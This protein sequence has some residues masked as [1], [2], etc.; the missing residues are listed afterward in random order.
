MML[1]WKCDFIPTLYFCINHKKKYSETYLGRGCEDSA[2]FWK[3]GGLEFRK[4][5]DPKGS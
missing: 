4:V 3:S 5:S 1:L 2:P